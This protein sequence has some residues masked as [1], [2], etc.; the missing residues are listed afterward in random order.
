MIK[1]LDIFPKAT[2]NELKVRTNA[3]G[4]LTI[5]SVAFLMFC[6]FSEIK[7]YLIVRESDKM[8]LN[9]N[10]LPLQLPFSFEIEVYNNC[11]HLHFELTNAKRTMEIDS[12]LSKKEFKQIQ[13]KCI[14][15]IEGTTANVPASFHIGLGDSYESENGAHQHLS[16]ILKDRN[17]SHKVS[18]LHF[19][20]LNVTSPIDNITT[21]VTKDSS[22]MFTYAIQLVP[23]FYQHKTGYY[24]ISSL[25]K[26]NLDKIRDKG[27]S[28]IIFEWNFSPI[29][30]QRSHYH[31]PMINLISH[32]LALCGIFFVF[33]RFIDTII[34]NLSYKN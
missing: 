21:I 8:I 12:H 13:E 34:F 26:T 16:F 4:L 9:D 5:F 27:I 24:A 14:V 33:V 10:P 15:R 29:G 18:Y 30:L 31:E 23:V 17:L 7:E 28:A 3:G 6:I 32:L 20:D 19:G 1:N 11:S 25:S 22:Y 2:D